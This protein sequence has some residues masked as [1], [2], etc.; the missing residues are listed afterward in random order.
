MLLRGQRKTMI[1]DV[2]KVYCWHED[3]VLELFMEL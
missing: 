2:V 3:S 1:S